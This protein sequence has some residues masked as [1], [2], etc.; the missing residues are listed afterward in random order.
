MPSLQKYFIE[1]NLNMK[2][3][4]NAYMRSVGK[5]PNFVWK[6]IEDSIKTVYYTKE[7]QM[8]RLTASY[9][10][11]RFLNIVIKLSF[12]KKEI[13]SIGISLKWFASTSL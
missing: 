9:P 7:E 5:D 13:N 3:T 2:E 8:L 10:S 11:T 12:Y 4:F 6:Q 1:L